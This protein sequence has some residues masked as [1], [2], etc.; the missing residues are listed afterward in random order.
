MNLGVLASSGDH[1]HQFFI[2]NAVEFF[3]DIINA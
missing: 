2:G 1:W 3:I